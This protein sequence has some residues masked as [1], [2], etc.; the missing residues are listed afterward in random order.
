MP[1]AVGKEEGGDEDEAPLEVVVS[2]KKRG[3]P[4]GSK[5]KVKTEADIQQEREE[6]QKAIDKVRWSVSAPG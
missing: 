6:R 4:K 2:N 3:R 5:N 1:V